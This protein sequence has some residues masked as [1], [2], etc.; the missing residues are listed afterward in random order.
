MILVSGCVNTRYGFSIYE[1]AANVQCY[2]NTYMAVQLALGT[3]TYAKRV[4]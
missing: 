4:Y 2:T 3:C 1:P